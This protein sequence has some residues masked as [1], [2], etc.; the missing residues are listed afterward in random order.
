M[1]A[2]LLICA[3]ACGAGAAVALFQGRRFESTA[4]R[5][6]AVV[7]DFQP[8]GERGR[9]VPF[10]SFT[11]AEGNEVRARAQRRGASGLQVGDE[12]TIAYT[13]KKVFGQSVWNIFVVRDEHAAPFRMYLVAGAV[14]AVLAAALL[15]GAAFALL[16]RT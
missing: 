12:V 11:D 15:A 14:L 1:A 10:V 2:A 9:M 13:Q 16:H 7:T 4:V 5:M 3:I 8:F 6:R